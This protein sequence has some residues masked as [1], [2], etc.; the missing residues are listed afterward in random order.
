MTVTVK[1]CE[2][3]PVCGAVRSV[4]VTMGRDR[5]FSNAGAFTI[6]QCTVC[7][8]IYSTPRLSVDAASAFYHAA[9]DTVQCRLTPGWV[10]W[11]ESTRF[12]RRMRRINA[13]ISELVSGGTLLDVG[14]GRGEFLFGMTKY[15]QWTLRGL[16]MNPSLAQFVAEVFHVPVL[17][18]RLDQAL[19]GSVMYDVITLW[20][21]FE[22]L[23]D[24]E[25]ALDR[26]KESLSRGGL[27]VVKMP[28][29][30]SLGARLFGACWSGWG[31]PQHYFTWPPE[32]FKAFV[33][34]RGLRVIRTRYLY[35]AY[36]DFVTS[37]GFAMHGIF[38]E[39][40]RRFITRVLALPPFMIGLSPFMA[41][42]R[43]LGRPSS[44]T[45][46][47]QHAE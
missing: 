9:G 33:Q 1:G 41:L 5:S 38:Q 40:V 3:C 44:V 15:R 26:L 22:H 11:L 46:F 16:E 14:C 4:A 24:P 32:A 39:R 8:V 43:A 31:V 2:A 28:N 12:K 6:R 42:E 7:K 10:R 35:G 37:V 23:R 29:P 27:L 18:G 34:E 17:T 20:D 30:E 19:P 13:E 21:V 45:Y 25:D 47:I 36:S